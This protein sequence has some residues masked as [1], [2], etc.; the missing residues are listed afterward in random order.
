MTREKTIV[1]EGPDGVE[2]AVVEELDYNET[3]DSWRFERELEGEVEAIQLPRERLYRITQTR[4]VEQQQGRD[5][6]GHP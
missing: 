5:E 1:Y 3:T 2:T 6:Y 4:S